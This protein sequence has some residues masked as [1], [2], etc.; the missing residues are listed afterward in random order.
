[1]AI[2]G[3][4]CVAM[5]TAVVMWSGRGDA[6]NTNPLDLAD[7]YICR[8][9]AD[10]GL[11]PGWFRVFPGYSA[12]ERGALVRYRCTFCNSHMPSNLSLEAE[13]IVLV[14]GIEQ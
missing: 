14:S 6:S 2:L 7:L 8:T 3:L 5:L 13:D 11:T 1:V 10:S 4:L 9:P 12:F